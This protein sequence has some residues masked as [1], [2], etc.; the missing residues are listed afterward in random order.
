[1]GSSAL[2]NLRNR[3][4]ANQGAVQQ[5]VVEPIVERVIQEPVHQQVH[6]PV[7]QQSVHTPQPVQQQERQSYPQHGYGNNSQHPVYA[8]QVMSSDEYHSNGRQHTSMEQKMNVIKVNTPISYSAPDK[9]GLSVLGVSDPSKVRLLKPAVLD[10]EPLILTNIRDTTGSISARLIDIMHKTG[11]TVL[12]LRECNVFDSITDISEFAVIEV[13][14]KKFASYTGSNYPTSYMDTLERKI[15]D[16]LIIAQPY[17]VTLDTD[18]NKYIINPSEAVLSRKVQFNG[19]E[20]E[21][22]SLCVSQLN[23]IYAYFRV[24]KCNVVDVENDF[25]R[26]VVGIDLEGLHY[27]VNLSSSHQSNYGYSSENI[28]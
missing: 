12:P 11:C 17:G 5:P 14:G 22:P 3:K 8:E 25:P 13:K 18:S 16:K 1:M 9:V 7:Y 28:I 23:Y 2:A 4:S 24:Y 10:V 20:V 26:L 27:D 6:Q 21:V 19:V 15:T